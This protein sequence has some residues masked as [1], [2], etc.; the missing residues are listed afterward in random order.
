MRTSDPAHP[1]KTITIQ[2]NVTAMPPDAPGGATL[3]PL[4]VAVTVSGNQGDWV[5]FTHTLGPDPADTAP[6]QGVQP[7]LRHAEGRGEV[8]HGVRTGTASYDMFGDGRDGVMP[9]SGNLD[10]NNGVGVAIVNSGSQGAYS[11]NVTDAYNGGR[12]NPGDVVLI[13]QTQGTGAGCWE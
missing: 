11:V 6:G 12:I 10:N 8:R 2:G 3:R 13:H 9:S 4:D 5:E 7:G 1:E